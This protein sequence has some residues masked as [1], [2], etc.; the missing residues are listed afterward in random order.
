MHSHHP[1]D[2]NNLISSGLGPV[3]VRNVMIAEGDKIKS[4]LPYYPSRAVARSDEACRER[5]AGAAFSGRPAPSLPMAR[6]HT[7]PT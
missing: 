4:F 5:G 1:Y 3:G 2:E 7:R 6:E